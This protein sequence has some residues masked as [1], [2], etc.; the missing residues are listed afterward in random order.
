MGVERTAVGDLDHD[1]DDDLYL[2]G[3]NGQNFMMRNEQPNPTFTDYTYASGTLKP[4]APLVSWGTVFLDY[5]NDGWLDLFY[6]NGDRKS[7]V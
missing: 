6:G 3:K 5:D 1:G 4:K 7:V 2:S